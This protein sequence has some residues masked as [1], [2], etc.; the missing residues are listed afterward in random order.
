MIGQVYSKAE[1][2][3]ESLGHLW[4]QIQDQSDTDRWVQENPLALGAIVTLFDKATGNVYVGT[5]HGENAV[6]REG[7]TKIQL[8]AATA[9]Q[10]QVIGNHKTGELAS[11]DIYETLFAKADTEAQDDFQYAYIA[12]DNQDFDPRSDKSNVEVT[13]I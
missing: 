10:L 12:Y 2:E 9:T 11:A 6:D 3:S 5:L 8:P 7:F 4:Q 1:Q 13:Y